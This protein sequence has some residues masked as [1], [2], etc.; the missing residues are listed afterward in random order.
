[1]KIS[2]IERYF[3]EKNILHFYTG[4]RAFGVSQKESDFDICIKFNKNYFSDFQDFLKL[5]NVVKEESNYSNGYYLLMDDDSK[6]N[7]IPLEEHIFETWKLCTDTIKG[8]CEISEP[9]KTK[10]R[11]KETRCALFEILKGFYRIV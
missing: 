11:N 4:S 6:V 5:N 2:D 7:I 9:I 1:M 10:L 8:A 3:L